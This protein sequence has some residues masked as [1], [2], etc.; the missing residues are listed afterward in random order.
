MI[1][2]IP[3]YGNHLLQCELCVNIIVNKFLNMLFSVFWF[4]LLKKYKSSTFTVLTHDMIPRNALFS[5][6]SSMTLAHI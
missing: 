1:L 2:V 6:G 3:F 5:S 4:M